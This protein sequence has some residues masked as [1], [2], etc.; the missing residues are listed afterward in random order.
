MCIMG[1]VPSSIL[2]TGSPDEVREY[3]R[4]LI[5]AVGK[6]GGF[7]L[8]PR[9]SIDEAKPENIKAMIDFTKEYGV[10]R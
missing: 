8:S 5:D 7:I 9:S 10:Y 4:K 6:D 1:N 2:Q 3:C